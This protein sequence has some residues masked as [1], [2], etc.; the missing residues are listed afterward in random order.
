MFRNYLKTAFRFLQRNRTFSVINI[1]GLS[2][3]TLCCLYIVL[4]VQE[5][6]SYDR[7]H[8]HTADLYRVNTLFGGK[9]NPVRSATT[10]PPVT[11]AMKREFPEIAQYA[12]V[13]S[14]EKFGIQQHLLQ[15][16][17]QSF[18]EKK[19]VLADSTLFDVFTWH[20]VA[21]DRVNPLGEP[22]S[23]VLLKPVA[24]KLFGKEDPVGKMIT[25]DNEYG[26]KLFRVTA[27]IDEN[28][29]R[30]HIQTSGPGPMRLPWRRNCLPSCRN[31]GESSCGKLAWKRSCSCKR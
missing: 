23:A 13:I 11:P 3:G 20:F 8:A 19:L 21:G 14:L 4:Y 22:N 18:Y 7:H 25:I 30:S 9:G 5:Q 29:G 27:V 2:L 17:D 24:D 26:K 16:K 28:L 12:R 10:S 6:Y 1:A 15:Y 31:M